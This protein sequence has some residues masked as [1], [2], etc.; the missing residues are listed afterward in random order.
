MCASPTSTGQLILPE[1]LKLLPMYTLAMLKSPLFARQCPGG[2]DA[3]A[4]LCHR[5]LSMTVSETTTQVYPKMYALHELQGNEA[6]M[7]PVFR[8]EDGGSSASSTQV[9]YL[10][11]P[12]CHSLS[13]KHMPAAG[14][15]LIDSGSRLIL[16]LRQESAQQSPLLLA[17]F[18]PEQAQLL[19]QNAHD[20]GVAELADATEEDYAEMN[21]RAR[22][23][24]LVQKLREEKS[25][26]AP[27]SVVVEQH[28]GP[29][30]QHLRSMLIDDSDKTA[31]SRGANAAAK[32][33]HAMSYVDFLCHVH[34]RIQDK[35]LSS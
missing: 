7:A 10:V 1:S 26:W 14:V 24:L 33:L 11:L 35:F 13:L 29:S 23:S 12:K 22:V 19:F 18:G 3:R 27:L 34:R 4:A 8:S 32:P 6:T 30:W 2:N 15:F 25:T 20:T 31:V 21:V 16:V 5:A 28:G 17:L 9:Q